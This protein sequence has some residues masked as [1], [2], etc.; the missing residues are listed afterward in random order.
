LQLLQI[1]KDPTLALLQ[2][3]SQAL[4]TID[5]GTLLHNL[6]YEIREISGTLCQLFIHSNRV[7]RNLQK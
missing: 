2:D 5:R 3:V 1:S 4:D 7:H 6:F